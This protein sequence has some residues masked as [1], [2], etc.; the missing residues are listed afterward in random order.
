[1]GDA[2]DDVDLLARAVDVLEQRSQLADDFAAM[3][4][5]DVEELLDARDLIDAQPDAA[6]RVARFVFV[7]VHQLEADLVDADFVE[8]VED[9]EN[10]NRLTFGNR[11]VREQ[12]IEDRARREAD[13]IAADVERRQRVAHAG[14]D[15]GVGDLAHRADGVEIELRELAEAAFVRLVRA[16]NRRDLITAERAR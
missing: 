2:L 12:E 8:L 13:E 3:I 6:D 16:P 7:A 11:R 10:V 9:A 14:D 4:V 5:L 1:I 15:L